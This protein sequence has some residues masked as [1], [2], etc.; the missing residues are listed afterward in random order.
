MATFAEH[1]ADLVHDEY[2]IA[3]LGLRPDTPESRCANAI[4]ASDELKA[5]REALRGMAD[6]LAEGCNDDVN[7]GDADGRFTLLDAR[8]TLRECWLAEYLPDGMDHVIAWV[9]G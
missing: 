4:L 6:A 7:H 1:L 2:D 8:S 5:I 9:V 3:D